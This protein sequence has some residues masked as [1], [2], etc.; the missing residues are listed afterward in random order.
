MG[1]A[2]HSPRQQTLQL[3]AVSSKLGIQQAYILATPNEICYF[4]C[5]EVEVG[6]VGTG[7][8]GLKACLEA[9]CLEH[10]LA[11]G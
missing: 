1:Q 6:W 8:Q 7:V 5:N 9:A 4:S 10:S 3:S 2:G 11:I